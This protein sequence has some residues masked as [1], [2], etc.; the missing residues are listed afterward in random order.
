MSQQSRFHPPVVLVIA[1]NDPSGG[2]G[3][4]A[5]TQAISRLACHP[6]PVLAALTVQDTVNAYAVEPVAAEFVVAQAEKVLADLPVRAIKLGLLASAET[7]AAVADLLE[8]HAEIPVVTDPVLVA[9]GGARLA[10]EQLIAVYRER[11]LPRTTVL[12]PNAH[13]LRA[14]ASSAETAAK[15]VRELLALGPRWVLAKGGDEPTP[16][17]D[18]TLHGVNGE[19]HDWHWERLAGQHH[20]SGC[21]LASAIAAELAKGHNAPSAVDRAQ[22]FTF[23]ALKNGWRLGKG[24]NI[25]NRLCP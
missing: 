16:R 6:A 19:T 3:I 9:A 25:P 8:R 23:E 10:E 4:A 13:E 21:T 7:G 22:A 14:L 1:G 2:A 17:V 18:N 20:G 12:T 11:L 5:D 24:Q 15:R